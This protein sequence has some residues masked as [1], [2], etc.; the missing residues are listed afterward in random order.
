MKYERFRR[1][2]AKDI[3]DQERAPDRRR[4]ERVLHE[5]FGP[6]DEGYGGAP[7]AATFFALIALPTLFLLIMWM[8]YL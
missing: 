1:Q 2:R 7:G 3:E 4:M 6:P 8:V 5:G